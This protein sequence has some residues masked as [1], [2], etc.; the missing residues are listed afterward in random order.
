L[1]GLSALTD[2]PR[3]KKSQE[4]RESWDRGTTWE[5][6]WNQVARSLIAADKPAYMEGQDSL[7]VY[8]GAEGSVWTESP[9]AESYPT[10]P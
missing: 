4:A 2:P 6:A 3:T 7:S 5:A 8:S 1:N 10:A 9:F